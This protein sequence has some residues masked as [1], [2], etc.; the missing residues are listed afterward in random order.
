V[1]FFH[2]FGVEGGRFVSDSRCCR[3][4]RAP[5]HGAAFGGHLS[6]LEFLVGRNADVNA[7]TK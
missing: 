4:G 7:Q 1:T 5:I 2:V 3:E 6:C